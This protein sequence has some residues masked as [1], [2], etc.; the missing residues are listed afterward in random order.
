[1]ADITFG[2][3]GVGGTG[4]IDRTRRTAKKS[5]VSSAQ[6]SGTQADKSELHGVEHAPS[7][8]EF[9]VHG[10]SESYEPKHPQAKAD[11]DLL[12]SLMPAG[13]H[14]KLGPKLDA[15]YRQKLPPQLVRELTVR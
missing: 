13:A 14:A 4:G 8:Q 5:S 11:S 7:I 10:R 1:M 15:M 6:T 12:K 3:G 2:P 9:A